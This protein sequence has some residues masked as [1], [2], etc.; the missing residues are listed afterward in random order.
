MT[1]SL[2]VCV[3]GAQCV[4]VHVKL[5]TFGAVNGDLADGFY[6]SP[7]VEYSSG[8]EHTNAR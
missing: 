7:A 1:P 5:L 6:H 2:S 3:C 4:R 8:H